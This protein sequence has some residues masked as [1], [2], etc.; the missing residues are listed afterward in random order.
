MLDVQSSGQFELMSKLSRNGRVTNTNCVRTGN[1]HNLEGTDSPDV[2]Y[3][4]F[5]NN[6]ATALTDIRGTLYDANGD[7]AGQPDA[8]LFD[9]LGPREAIFLTRGA[10]SSI[11]GATWPG[12]ASLVLSDTYENL[13]LMNLNF[14]NSETFFNFSCYV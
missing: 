14:V 13:Q 8:L 6:G 9:E 11:V 3:I 12:V 4:R 2:S 5:I 10:V 7:P 1:V